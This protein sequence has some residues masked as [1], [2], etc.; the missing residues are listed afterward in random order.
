MKTTENNY[1]EFEVE[2]ITHGVNS[3]LHLVMSRTVDNIQLWSNDAWKI[4]WH[5]KHFADFDFGIDFNAIFMQF[6]G[7]D[8]HKEIAQLPGYLEDVKHD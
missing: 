3:W 8:S 7:C 4:R 1:F 2:E 5:F 6:I